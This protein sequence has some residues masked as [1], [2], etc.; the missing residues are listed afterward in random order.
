MSPETWRSHGKYFSFSTHQIF[1]RDEGNGPVLLLLHGFPTASWDWHRIW[2]SLT[3]QFRVIAPDMVGFGFSDKPR[4]YRYTIAEQADLH[5]RLLEHL[6]VQ[7]AHLFSHDYGVSVVQELLARELDDEL[8][9]RPLSCC[10]L[11]GGLFINTYRPRPIQKLLMSAIGPLMS[12]FLGRRNLAKTFRDIFGPQTQPSEE[13]IDHF[14][15]LIDYH[16]G[17]WVIPRVIR[18]MQE[19]SEF[20]DRWGGRMPDSKVP[21]R[22]IN[23]NADPISGRHVAQ[24]YEDFIPNA[25]VVHLPEIGHYPQVEAPDEVLQYFWEF[26]ER[27]K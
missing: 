20:R 14:W 10:F 13:E 8:S 19:R 1:Y 5:E 16:N 18:Y 11:N 25:D 26:M 27:V 9:F 23:G 21:M 3:E 12:P 22:L 4:P 6:G 17:K 7:E 2:S 24:F 15:S